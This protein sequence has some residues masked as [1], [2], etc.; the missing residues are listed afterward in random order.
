MNKTNESAEQSGR[1]KHSEQPQSINLTPNTFKLGFIINPIA[2]LG[3]S[4]ALKGSDGEGIVQQAIQLGATAK[5]NERATI[6]LELL[7]PYKKQLII[8]TA[9]GAMGETCAK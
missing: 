9:S 3:G 2:G 8:Y 7:L 4:V 6:A 1:S 5:A